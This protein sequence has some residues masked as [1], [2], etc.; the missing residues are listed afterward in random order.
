MGFSK[1]LIN[2]VRACG[3]SKYR[4][5]KES[6]V[7]IATLIRFDKGSGLA[8]DTVDKLVEFLQLELRPKTLPR[9]QRKKS[10]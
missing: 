4:I 8:L 2:A 6:G 7:D 5:A 10:R 3:K 1:Q 9:K